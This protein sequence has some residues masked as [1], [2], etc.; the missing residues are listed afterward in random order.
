M[1]YALEAFIC[2]L[3]KIDENKINFFLAK[4]FW[5]KKNLCKNFILEKNLENRKICK[6]FTEIFFCR[7]KKIRRKKKL[8]FFHQKNSKHI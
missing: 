2:V 3:K 7:P 8:F 5:S 6:I 4:K 1:P